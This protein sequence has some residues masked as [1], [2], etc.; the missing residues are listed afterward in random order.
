VARIG[1]TEPRKPTNT[2]TI[3]GAR[4][5][6]APAGARTQPPDETIKQTGT[7]HDGARGGARGK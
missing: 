5:S 6:A 2:G 7:F 4:S 3:H 1:I